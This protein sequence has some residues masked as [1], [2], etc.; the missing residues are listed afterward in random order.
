MSD[1]RLTDARLERDLR[2]ITPSSAPIGLQAAI[3]AEIDV[4]EQDRGVR[5]SGRCRRPSAAWC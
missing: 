2:D 4:T 1:P 5:V 3:R